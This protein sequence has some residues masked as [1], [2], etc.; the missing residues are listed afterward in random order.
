MEKIQTDTKT[1]AI[2]IEEAQR[3]RREKRAQALKSRRR[4]DKAAKV[5]AEK[6]RRSFITGRRI[7]LACV[8]SAV[9]F[10]IGSSAYRIIGLKAQEQNAAEE[11]KV[12][13]EQKARLESE[14]TMLAEDEYI[15]EQARER[16]GMV[17]PGEVVYVFEGEDSKNGTGSDADN[18][19]GSDTGSGA[20]PGEG[21]STGSGPDA[22]P[23]SG[24]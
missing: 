12:K 17:K 19:A 22:G 3:E 16:L 10:F 13:T 4:R 14:F 15:E 21:A 11:L 2:D 1:Y 24:E 20:D 8:V 18:S 9:V 6:A 7:I 5:E 23:G